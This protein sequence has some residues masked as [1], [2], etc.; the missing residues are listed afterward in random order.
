MNENRSNRQSY[1]WSFVLGLWIFG[2]AS[3]FFLRFSF[4]FY[5]ANQSAVDGVLARWFP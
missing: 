4:A 3:F 1:G 5:Y 2:S